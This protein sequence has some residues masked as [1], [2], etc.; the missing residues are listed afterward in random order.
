MTLD[1]TSLRIQLRE[2]LGLEGN[3]TQTLPD[4]DSAEKSGADTFLNRS[5]WE[6]LEKFNF[7]EK[8]VIGSFPLVAG[9]NYYEIPTPFDALRSLSIEDLNSLA[10]KPLDRIDRDVFEQKY[11]NSADSQGKP[12][13]Y[14]REDMGIRLWPTPDQ[15]YTLTMSYWDS[16]S[17]LSNTNTT[18]PIPRAWHEL[19]LHGAIWRAKAGPFRDYDGAK[20]HRALQGSLIEG[21]STTDTKEQFDSHRAGVEVLG[22]D[23]DLQ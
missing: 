23:Y 22:L 7:R 5:Y 13:L 15:V 3:D 17:D 4:T 10:H 6:L 2:G 19:V 1:L 9:E 20:F 16:L 8:E 18:P 11:V 12:E 14:F 21:I